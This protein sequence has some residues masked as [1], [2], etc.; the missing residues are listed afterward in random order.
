MKTEKQIKQRL[1]FL[2]ELLETGD[3]SEIDTARIHA[4]FLTLKW[5]L[6]DLKY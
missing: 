4:G 2:A 6:S 1:K 5:V 3:Y